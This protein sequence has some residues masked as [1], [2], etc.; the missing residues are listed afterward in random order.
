MSLS[1]MDRT[2][3]GLRTCVVDDVHLSIRIA[4]LLGTLT[5]SIRTKFV[6][7]AANNGP[8][9]NVSSRSR[10]PMAA[11]ARNPPQQEVD[12]GQGGFGQGTTTYLNP[13]NGNAYTYVPAGRPTADA[14]AGI[15]TE[16]ID[17]T[18]SNVI[19]MPP[20][21]FSSSNVYGAYEPTNNDNPTFGGDDAGGGY[22]ADWLALPLDPLLNSSGQGVSQG[23]AGFGPDVGNFDM[24]DI[25]L[26]DHY[27]SEGRPSSSMFR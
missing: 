8:G 27:E 1:L 4:D 22:M 17:P 9:Y 19:F 7:L 12:R 18:D 25:L 3:E 15:A 14:L 16:S 24:L 13:M 10:S 5:S 26:N 2:I 6:R 21:D 11:S 23:M 20:P